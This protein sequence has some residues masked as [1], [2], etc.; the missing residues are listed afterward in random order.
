MKVTTV[1]WGTRKHYARPESSRTLCGLVG[2]VR[3]LGVADCRRCA[4]ILMGEPTNQR[5]A[6]EI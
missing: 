5:R 3:A 1:T 2:G 4:Q 6:R